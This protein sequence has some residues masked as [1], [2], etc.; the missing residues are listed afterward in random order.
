SSDVCSSDLGAFDGRGGDDPLPRYHDARHL[1]AES[2]RALSGLG[3]RVAVEV[4]GVAHCEGE[5]SG[6]LTKP[7]LVGE[8]HRLWS[9]LVGVTLR[10][11]ISPVTMGPSA[12][13]T[14]RIAVCW[15]SVT[16]IPKATRSA[17][18]AATAALM[19]PT[20]IAGSRFMRDPFGRA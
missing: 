11:T 19:V 18:T 15:S 1:G 8:T 9:L 6:D 10:R 12:A 7:V 20:V 16:G 4:V 5:S 3:V 14:P 17:R 13:T 2:D